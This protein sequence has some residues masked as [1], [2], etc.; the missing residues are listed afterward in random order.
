MNTGD[1]VKCPYCDGTG[2][3]GWVQQYHECVECGGSGNLKLLKCDI[4]YIKERSKL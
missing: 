3:E 4:K 1:V 2:N